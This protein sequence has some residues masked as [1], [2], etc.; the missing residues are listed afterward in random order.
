MINYL[1]LAVSIL[2]ACANNV[3]LHL[4]RDSKGILNAVKFNAFCSL[5]WVVLL[6]VLLGGVPVINT[7]TLFFG[8]IYGL[9]MV[10]FLFFKY[11]ALS[12][13][14]VSIT[15]FLGNCSLVIS[16][17]VGV[18]FWKESV[19]ILQCIGVAL[20]IAAFYLCAY[21]PDGS[22]GTAKWKAYTIGFFVF[23]ALSSIV[24]KCFPQ[25]IRFDTKLISSL[26]WVTAVVM[27]VAHF[28][29]FGAIKIKTGEK[30][31]F[32]KK[33]YILAM[34]CGVVSCSYNRL[35][36]TLTGVIDS[37]IFF[38]VFNGA[39]ILISLITGCFIFKERLNRRQVIGFII[40]VIALALAGKVIRI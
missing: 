14:P 24:L 35:N 5:V 38:P 37:I 12:T 4:R 30:T 23:A 33:D 19:T 7:V 18:I 34:V 1:L 29:L 6:T 9:A 3:F 22:K 26:L 25:E 16:T 15:T 28:A 31:A 21:S 39:I 40:G 8:C 10:L 17:A 2:C 36:S 11:Q 13:G 27:T 32:T 20:L